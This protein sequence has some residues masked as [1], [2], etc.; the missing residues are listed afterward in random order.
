MYYFVI[1]L[2]FSLILSWRSSGNTFLSRTK[3]CLVIFNYFCSVL[4]YQIPY[5]FRF[6]DY[7]NY[8]RQ[9]TASFIEIRSICII[10]KLFL[11][12]DVHLSMKLWH[13]NEKELCIVKIMVKYNVENGLCWYIPYNVSVTALSCLMSIKVIYSDV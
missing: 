4:I 12:L 10:T 13:K 1:T 11:T 2:I 7:R 8:E 9:I 6:E 5:L 3:Y